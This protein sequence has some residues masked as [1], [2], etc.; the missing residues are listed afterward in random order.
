MQFVFAL[1]CI[2]LAVSAS[3]GTPPSQGP[4]AGPG[5]LIFTLPNTARAGLDKANLTY[6]GGPTITSAKV[7]LI[8]WGPSFSNPASPDWTYAHTLQAFRDQLGTTPEYNTITQYSGIMLS[9]L[10]SGTPDWFDASTPPTNVTD[11]I[12]R[13]HVTAYLSTHTFNSS[14]IY[15]VV[16]P[17]TSYASSGTSTSCGGPSL[18]F[19]A[20]HGWFNSGASTVKYIVL[21]YPSC[22]GCQVPGWTDVQNAEHFLVHE[23]REAVTDST[24]GGW[25]D[26]LGNEADDKCAWSPTPFIGTGGYAYQY[27]WSNLAGACVKTR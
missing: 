18:A 19:C 10:G 7:V 4:C 3:A 9:N 11:S 21:P 8:F 13:S 6:H 27:E 2:L 24:G 20:Y 14:T 1:S 5:R 15:T 23:I 22:S 25:F 16:L 12:V 26:S 17:R